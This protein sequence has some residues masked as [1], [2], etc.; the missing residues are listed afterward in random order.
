MSVLLEDL[1]HLHTY[2]HAMRES[3]FAISAKQQTVEHIHEFKQWQ[4]ARKVKNH[5]S[6]PP[7]VIMNNSD[8]RWIIITNKKD[9]QMQTI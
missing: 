1:I 9:R 2:H 5:R 4:A 7:M 6:W 8:L 3:L